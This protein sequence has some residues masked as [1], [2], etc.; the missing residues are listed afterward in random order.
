MGSYSNMGNSILTDALD[1]SNVVSGKDAQIYITLSDGTDLFLAEVDTFSAQLNVN[2]TKIQPIGTLQEQ[3]VPIST[4][5][6]ISMTEIVIRD[7]VMLEKLYA[8][9]RNGFI[10]MFNLMGKLRRRDGKFQR[11]VFRQCVP[12]GTIDLFNISPGEIIKRQ[13]NFAVNGIPELQDYFTI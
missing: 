1:V 9:M 3:S 2:N 4:S 11:Q 10:P 8:D 7:D 13:W 5:V 12:D 6:S